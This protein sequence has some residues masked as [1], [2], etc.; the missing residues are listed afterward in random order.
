MLNR[1]TQG[2]LMSNRKYKL[3]LRSHDCGNLPFT[4]VNLANSDF[5]FEVVDYDLETGVYKALWGTATIEIDDTDVVQY[6]LKNVTDMQG[7]CD[8]YPEYFI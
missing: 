8:E 5:E 2:K 6:G 1:L 4:I 3:I 7:L